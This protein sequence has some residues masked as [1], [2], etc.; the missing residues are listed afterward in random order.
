MHIHVQGLRHHQYTFQ[1]QC[2]ALKSSQPTC[3]MSLWNKWTLKKLNQIQDVN[4]KAQVTS[5][6]GIFLFSMDHYRVEPHPD[7]PHTCQI[8]VDS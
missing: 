4:A 8:L 6:D 3:K 2:M 1:F 7:A 5:E